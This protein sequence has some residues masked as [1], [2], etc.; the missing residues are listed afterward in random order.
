MPHD[1]DAHKQTRNISSTQPKH[2][3][4]ALTWPHYSDLPR[5][6]A[7]TAR[8]AIPTAFCV[9]ARACAGGQAHARALANQVPSKLHVHACDHWPGHAAWAVATIRA[10]VKF[11]RHREEVWRVRPRNFFL[12]ILVP[13]EPKLLR[14]QG[15]AR[16]NCQDTHAALQCMQT[17]PYQARQVTMRQARAPY[18]W[19]YRL[20]VYIEVRIHSEGVFQEA[21]GVESARRDHHYIWKRQLLSCPPRLWGLR[22]NFAK[23]QVPLGN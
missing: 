13:Q 19:M 18:V 1:D 5:V 3:T 11:Y 4:H 22:K 14:D 15:A 20:W 12:L 23:N 8:C 21:A 16:I 2:S 9:H 17:R 7:L 6:A 10:R